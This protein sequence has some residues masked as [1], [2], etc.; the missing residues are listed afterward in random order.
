LFEV[1]WRRGCG[2]RNGGGDLNNEQCKP[3]WNYNNESP[4]Y[5]KYILIKNLK[6]SQI[7]AVYFYFGLINAWN[8]IIFV[9]NDL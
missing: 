7:N 3:I 5:N 1:G 9:H 6:F 2:G 8:K 4:L